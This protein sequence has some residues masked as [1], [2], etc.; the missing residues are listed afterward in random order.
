MKKKIISFVLCVLL[1]IGICTP[2]SAAELSTETAVTTETTVETVDTLATETDGTLQ[3]SSE[4]VGASLNATDITLYGLTSA[5]AE[6]LTIPSSLKQSFQIVVNNAGNVSYV[7]SS[8]S[9]I[10][11]SNTGLVEINY[12]TWYYYDGYGTTQPPSEGQTPNRIEKDFRTGDAV[13]TV[14][15][16]GQ[17]Y[18][19]N[20]HVV[21]YAN[22][23]ADQVIEDYI[24]ENIT[25]DLIDMELMKKIAAFPA[26]Y[27]YSASYSGSTAM[28]VFG[29]GDCWA[30]T[31]AI[32][33][34]CDK[35]GIEAWVRNGNKDA[36]A[37]SGHRNA[38]VSYNGKYYEL[39]A[40]YVGTAPRAYS[41]IERDS[42]FCYRSSDSGVTVYQ[43]DGHDTSP[44]TLVIPETLREKNVI[45]IEDNF[46]VGS[47]RANF[48]SIQ[49]PDT[50]TSIGKFAFASFEKVTTINIPASVT[51]IE[52]GA[53][54]QCSSLKNFNCAADNP[55]FSSADGVLY[56]KN[57]QTVV[58]AP[59][60]ETITLPDTVSSM[61]EGA[62]SYNFNLKKV[63]LPENM[64]AISDNV[65]FYCDFLEKIY[66][67]KSVTSIGENAFYRCDDMTIYGV[68]GSYAQNYA[69]ENDI[70]FVECTSGTDPVI[71]LDPTTDPD[72][73]PAPDPTTDP[74]PT[75]DSTP[76]VAVSYRTHVQSF[77]WQGYVTNGTISG[78]SGKAKR[79]E[80]INIS[81]NGNTNLGIRYTTH[82]QSYG[83]LPW[84]ANGEMNGT[85]GESKRLEAI[86]IQLTGADKDK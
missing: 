58:S 46:A 72:P 6:K 56:D 83:W 19:V 52:T 61:E 67:P 23:Y 5:Y 62:F 85:E 20:V 36:G 75:P 38:V 13:I 18:K 51:E 80:A 47:L 4:N 45:A 74:D 50:V 63:I 41:V 3:E 14:T 64:T 24:A 69:E 79:L 86:K 29:G 49:L 37:G 21:D 44:K 28:I 7:V 55:Y 22:Y 70:N 82:C 32:I 57:K 12:T 25:S 11:V 33:K 31:S 1:C 34:I 68:A 59:G 60:V 78:T 2:I 48:T 73:V 15:A 66:I 26:N 76:A 27:N 16:D 35:L 53:F 77:G 84:S 40:G 54:A 39:E 65:F 43:Y 81:V 8:G 30:S 10:T 71:D 17:T 42:L 9:N